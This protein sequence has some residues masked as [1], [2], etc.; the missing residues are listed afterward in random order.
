MPRKQ[1]AY[2]NESI[3]SLKGADRVRKR[4]GVIFGSDGI[5]GCA[6]SIFE[7]LSNAIDEA[8]EG[9]GNQI[10]IT[11]FRDN[12]IEIEDFGRGM[13]VDFNKNE[14][15]F[16]WELLFCEMYAGG[17]YSAGEDNYEYSLGLNGLGLC[18]TQYAS[19]WMT[20]DIYRDG[21]HY[22][23][24]FRKGENVGGL[25]KE[26]TNRK[27][28]GSVIRWKPDTDVFTDIAVPSSY[29]LEV[30]KR[31]AIVNAG[32]HFNF[33]DETGAEKQ[34]TEFCYENG[35]EDFVEEIADNESLTPVI[36]CQS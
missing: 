22:H 32:V 3:T 10:N 29:Y 13:P 35:I 28:T 23:L 19:E 6:H 36:F 11:K 17:K 34:V 30:I 9:F 7:I 15:K 21:Y 1:A 27:R 31:Q 26:E 18:A 8:R 2:T 33:T 20:A 24:D 16:N 4:P 12:S 5:D 14:D 25:K